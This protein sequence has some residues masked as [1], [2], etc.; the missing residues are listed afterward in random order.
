MSR[1]RY[2]AAPWLWW[3]NRELPELQIR[4]LLRHLL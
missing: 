4:L 2:A 3:W 1:M